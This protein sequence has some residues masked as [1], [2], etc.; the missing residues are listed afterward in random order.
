MK[1]KDVGGI[2]N[3]SEI[4]CIMTI[5]STVVSSRGKARVGHFP[6]AVQPKKR[7]KS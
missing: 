7:A 5:K 4:L 3:S 6:K 1:S 2:D